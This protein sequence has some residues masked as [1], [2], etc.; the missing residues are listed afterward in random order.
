MSTTF[1][2]LIETKHAEAAQTTQFT[3]RSSSTEAIVSVVDSFTVTNTGS[4]DAAFS[5]NV[6]ANG[7]SPGADNLVLRERTI[8]PN[9]TYTCPELVGQ[10][11]GQGDY[12]STLASAADTLTIRAS[13]REIAT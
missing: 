2:A 8:T 9:E 3:S 1:F 6:V 10:T 12:L 4:A 11:L 5:C 7:E 13:G